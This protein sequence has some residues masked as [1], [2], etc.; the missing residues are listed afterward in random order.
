MSIVLQISWFIEYIP[1]WLGPAMVGVGLFII[2]IKSF[3]GQIKMS[4][5]NSG[6]KQ[7]FP[8]FAGPVGIGLSASLL[9]MRFPTHFAALM[10]LM[11]HWIKGLGVIRFYQK[12]YYLFGNKSAPDHF[13]SGILYYGSLLF[14]ITSIGWV[15][16]LVLILTNNTDT[17]L[18]RIGVLL[19][20]L[21]A[22]VAL[23]GFWQRSQSLAGVEDMENNEMAR[24]FQSQMTLFGLSLSIAGAEITNLQLST[25]I[26]IFLIGNVVYSIGFWLSLSIW[27]SSESNIELAD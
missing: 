2:S 1:R 7:M 21:T 8:R 12:I 5:S 10:V 24:V 13:G 19:T 25:N 15:A 22:L 16:V 6:R 23:V 11:G 17:P 18:Y 14:V 4:K 27:I 3:S 26:L 9:Y 20:L